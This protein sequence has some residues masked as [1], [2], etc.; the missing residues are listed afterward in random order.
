[1]N[2]RQKGIRRKK[3]K[4]RRHVKTLVVIKTMAEHA[5]VYQKKIRNKG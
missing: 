2:E 3:K 1:M 4:F 5:C